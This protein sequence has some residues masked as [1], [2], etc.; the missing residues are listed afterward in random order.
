[1]TTAE[2]AEAPARA[3]AKGWLRVWAQARAVIAVGLVVV[4]WLIWIRSGFAEPVSNLVIDP[5]LF[6]LLTATSLGSSVVGLLLTLRRPEVRIGS[7]EAWMGLITGW[8]VLVWAWLALGTTPAQEDLPGQAWLAV[9]VAALAFPIGTAIQIAIAL[10]FPEDR[11]LSPRWAWV[12][13]LTAV[14]GLLASLASI[15]QP[16]PV[17]FFGGQVN[18]FGA[19]GSEQASATLQLIGS[20]GLVVGALLAA[21]SL[22]QRYAASGGL[23]RVQ[24]RIFAASGVVLALTFVPFAAVLYGVVTDPTW[25]RVFTV[26]FFAVFAIGPVTIAV[27]IV[28]YRLYELDHL[29]GRTFV[30]GLL[31]AILA[32]MYAAGVRLFQ[33]L[34]VA[35][36]GESSDAALVITTLILATTFTPIKMRLER[37]AARWTTERR[38]ETVAQAAAS[39]PSHD[40]LREEI[41]AIVREELVREYEAGTR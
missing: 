19:P 41:R 10:L 14:S 3:G 30:Y 2:E 25:A 22:I 37:V 12:A 17:S 20:I 13:A 31:T 36:T 6:I 16:G 9:S 32:G 29:V 27:A 38:T 11:L 34:F 15:L 24:I 8:N 18:P 5:L 21:A 40:E 35:F 39:Y 7:L 1:M 33:S 26:L 28:R 23:E 4:A